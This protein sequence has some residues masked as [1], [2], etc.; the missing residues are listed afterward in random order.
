MKYG[1]LFDEPRCGKTGLQGFLD[2]L[3]HKLGCAV[4]EDGQRLEILYSGNR[5]IVLAK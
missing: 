1:L 2:L 3:Q 5:E 4:R